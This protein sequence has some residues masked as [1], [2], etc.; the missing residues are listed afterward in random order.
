MK[1]NPYNI[2][3]NDY[4]FDFDE[5]D[6]SLKKKSPDMGKI[7]VVKIFIKLKFRGG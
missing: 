3:N 5:A 2:Y 7:C 6:A 1:K 4:K